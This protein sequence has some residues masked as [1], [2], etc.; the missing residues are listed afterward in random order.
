MEECLIAL[1]R[2]DVVDDRC[3]YHL[4]SF[5]MKFAQGLFLKLVIA[6]SIP[7]LSVIEV[8]PR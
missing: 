3:G 5:E 8:V 4:V 2:G 7:A 6:E 1:V